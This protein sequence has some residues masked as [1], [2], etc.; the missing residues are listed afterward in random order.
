MVNTQK[1]PL[2]I[3]DGYVHP[4]ERLAG[5][6]GRGLFGK[7]RLDVRSDA[8][9]SGIRVGAHYGIRIQQPLR[10]LGIGHTSVVGQVGHPQPTGGLCSLTIP[11][12]NGDEHRLLPNAP[13]ATVEQ[14]ITFFRLLVRREIPIIQLDFPGKH[15][16]LIRL[17]HCLADLLHHVP[18][19]L[20]SLQPQP[21]L[22]VLCRNRLGRTRHQ[23]H[24]GVPGVNGQLAVHHDRAA[25]NGR[26]RPAIHAFPT[27]TGRKPAHAPRVTRPAS[28]PIFLAK[29]SHV[30]DAARLIREAFEKFLS[31]HQLRFEAKSTPSHRNPLTSYNQTDKHSY[32]ITRFHR[33][34]TGIFRVRLCIIGI[35]CS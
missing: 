16:R 12:F 4:R 15:H 35:P 20:I 28:Q 24:A 29:G 21:L 32:Q 23:K 6:F 7:V 22:H 19:R 5:V 10:Q 17:A 27:V 11:G 30:L 31:R 13:T 25:A 2:C 18:N 14:V 34:S 8:F 1:Q 3:A 33:P 26:F 9:V